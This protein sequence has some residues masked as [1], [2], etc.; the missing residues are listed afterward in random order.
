M[1]KYTIQNLK[2][3]PVEQAH[4]GSGSRQVLVSPDKMTT[5]YFEAMTKGY[6]DPGKSYD[7]HSHQDTDEIFFVIK[8]EGKFHSENE[9]IEFKEGDIVTIYANSTHKIEAGGSSTNEYYFIRVK[10]K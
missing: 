4:G 8:G 2:D 9:V 10:C 1:K 3:I 5:P 6:L 7:W